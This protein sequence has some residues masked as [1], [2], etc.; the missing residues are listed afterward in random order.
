VVRTERVV[1]GE[2]T[3]PSSQEFGCRRSTVS[4]FLNYFFVTLDA[5]SYAEIEKSDFLKDEF[6]AYGQRTTV[7]TDQTYTAQLAWASTGLVNRRSEEA[8]G[9]S[10]DRR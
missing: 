8:A 1:L 3:V 2:G 6:A 9:R 4:V 7:W 5:A 10:R